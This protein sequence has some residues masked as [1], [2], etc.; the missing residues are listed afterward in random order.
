MF[1]PCVYMCMCVCVCVCGGGGGDLCMQRRG[2]IMCVYVCAS[3]V[4]RECLP[5]LCA[6]VF[7]RGGE[8]LRMQ[9]R[10]LIVFVQVSLSVSVCPL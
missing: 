4:E 9:G 8:H 3:E 6:C 1:A 2:L 5:F 10:G 7:Y